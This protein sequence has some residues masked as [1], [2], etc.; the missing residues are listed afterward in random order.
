MQEHGFDTYTASKI[1]ARAYKRTENSISKGF[2][3]DFETYAS[4]AYSSNFI[5]YDIKGDRLYIRKTGED[6]ST[7]SFEK[8]Y[9][10]KR[11]AIFAGKYSQIQHYVDLYNRDVISLENLNFLIEGF[12]LIN[13]DYW[14][15]GS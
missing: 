11:L 12:K 7:S 15:E 5:K 3:I 6:I 13:A 9:T 14:K 8:E 2:N 4:I 10:N 1:Y